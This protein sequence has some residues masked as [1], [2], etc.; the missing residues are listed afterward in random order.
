MF[1]MI[2]LCMKWIN[3]NEIRDKNYKIEKEMPE[4]LSANPFKAIFL[5]HNIKNRVKILLD[6]KGTSWETFLGTGLWFHTTAG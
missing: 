6:S 4:I 2:R 3:Y 5:P 1:E